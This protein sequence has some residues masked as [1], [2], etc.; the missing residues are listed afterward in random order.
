MRQALLLM[1]FQRR[2][3]AAVPGVREAM[4]VANRARVAARAAGIPVIHVRVAFRNGH[5]E[6]PPWVL[7]FDGLLGTDI[8]QDSN[9][10][11]AFDLKPAEG[12]TVVTKRFYSAF[13]HGYLDIVLRAAGIQQVVMAGI[14][15][16][17]VVLS[18]ARDAL[19]YGYRGVVLSDGCADLD[20][21]VHRVLLDKVIPRSAQVATVDEWIAGLAAA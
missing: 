15:T 10:H 12:E 9:E 8:L 2:A 1:D 20:P 16:F 18:T 21:E 17:G 19:E 4:A 11:T 7:G 14:A 13:P 5:P 3:V 6:I